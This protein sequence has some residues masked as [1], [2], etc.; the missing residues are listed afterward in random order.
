MAGSVSPKYKR[1]LISIF[2][3]AILYGTAVLVLR[4]HY[5]SRTGEMKSDWN[6]TVLKG[7]AG[8]F[9]DRAVSLSSFRAYDY[10]MVSK[11]AYYRPPGY[12]VFMA[13]LFLASG[14]SLKAVIL[15][16]IL[17]SAIIV[18]LIADTGRILFDENIGILAGILTVLYYPLWNA[19]VTINSELLSM[20][21]WSASLYLMFMFIRK[22]PEKKSL[23]L[24]SGLLSGLAALTRGQFLML[25]PVSLLLI[26]FS[27]S[28]GRKEKFIAAS[29]WIAMFAVPV[30]LWALYSYI[31]SG[32]FVI[33]STQG[34]YSLWWGWSPAVV[35]E[36][37][38]PVWNN[39]WSSIV[40]PPDQIGVLLSTKSGGWFLSEVYNFITRYPKESSLIGLFKLMEAWG[41]EFYNG[42]SL[43]KDSVRFV[44]INWDLILALPA[45]VILLKARQN[46][47]FLKFLLAASV[48]YTVISVLTAALY[49]YRFPSL[50]IFFLIL[51]SF[52]ILYVFRFVKR[53]KADRK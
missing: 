51:S 34:M 27:D 45:V 15:L 5:E 7:D 43:L 25:A 35:M 24:F 40:V 1:V 13:L 12:P 48:V 29:G 22:M 18:I 42:Q 28:S 50:D 21:F 46:S 14:A 39:D 10:G 23:L 31:V 11:V 16:Q 9:F 38:Y 33:V 30:L 49:R 52:T 19:A 3:A 6:V 37:L 17:L 26:Y 41:I 47:V 32:L 20:L 4:N 44:K 2:I 53:M 36:E 8:N